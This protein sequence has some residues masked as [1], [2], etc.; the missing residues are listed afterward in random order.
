MVIPCKIGLI[1]EAGSEEDLFIK[2]K[3]FIILINHIFESIF[4][5]NMKYGDSY[6]KVLSEGMR[7]VPNV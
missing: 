4:F 5:R 1:K 7:R 6:A 3:Y 2:Y